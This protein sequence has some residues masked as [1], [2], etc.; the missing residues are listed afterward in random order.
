MNNLKIDMNIII[1]NQKIVIA[2]ILG[3]KTII[4][5]LKR[6][7]PCNWSG[8]GKST[9][10]KKNKLIQVD[11]SIDY[12]NNKLEEME[13]MKKMQLANHVVRYANTTEQD[14]AVKDRTVHISMDLK[15]VRNF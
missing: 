2:E 15:F 13:E 9:E 1:E 5:S 11:L 14:S 3:I 10:S 6:Q 7:E 12:L 8:C 4:E